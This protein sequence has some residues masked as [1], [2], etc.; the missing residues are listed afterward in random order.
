[1]SLSKVTKEMLQ[2]VAWLQLLLFKILDVQRLGKIETFCWW[3]CHQIIRPVAP[4]LRSLL[5]AWQLHIS[6][7]KVSTRRLGQFPFGMGNNGDNLRLGVSDVSALRNVT[8]AL[9]TDLVDLNLKSNSTYDIAYLFIFPR[10]CTSSPETRSRWARQLYQAVGG[11]ADDICSAAYN[12]CREL[13]GRCFRSWP[14]MLTMATQP[15]SGCL[16]WGFTGLLRENPCFWRENHGPRV[17]V[18]MLNHYFLLAA[19]LFS[20][21]NLHDKPNIYLNQYKP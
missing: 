14:P 20:E 21:I 5:Q 6:T 17:R 11:S 7:P 9:C 1:M 16:L 15:V 3:F 18:M 19:A 2:V 12:L 4:N 10:K 13:S 8:N